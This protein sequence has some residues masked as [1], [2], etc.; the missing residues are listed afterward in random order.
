M[1]AIPAT[2]RTTGWLG[3]PETAFPP[4]SAKKTESLRLV[5]SP[6]QSRTGWAHRTGS[7]GGWF[8]R[9]FAILT[10]IFVNWH[11]HL[12]SCS[13][14]LIR[15][16]LFYSFL[17]A[18][19]IGGD[20]APGLGIPFK[21]RVGIGIFIQPI[22]GLVDKFKKG[23]FLSS[24]ASPVLHC[25]FLTQPIAVMNPSRRV[26]YSCSFRADQ[27][28]DDRQ[29]L[30]DIIRAMFVWPLMKDLLAGMQVNATIF[31]PSRGCRNRRHPRNSY[32]E[33]ANRGEHHSPRETGFPP[34]GI[35]SL[36][37]MFGCGA[38]GKGFVL[39][40]RKAM[41]LVGALLPTGENPGLAA[42]PDHI[43]LAFCIRSISLII[44][45]S[46]FIQFL[47]HGIHLR[48]RS[49]SRPGGYSSGK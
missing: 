13:N 34:G 4:L 21:D 2:A 12:Y 6:P 15:Y 3:H 35:L 9:F 33:P 8:R 32:R 14:D 22:F 7:W 47:G 18:V 1:R 44:S 46:L 39:G 10:D 25:F 43:K 41:H 23:A 5:C 38:A 37:G 17:F 40:A 19:E 27:R 45:S 20:F 31:Q 28:L 30:S 49:G 42:F 29:E 36:K 48:Q 16:Y 26:I 11:R 24:A